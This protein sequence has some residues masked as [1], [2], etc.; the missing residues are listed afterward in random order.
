MSKATIWRRRVVLMV[1]V[2]LAVA[3][4]LTLVLRDGGEEG[5]D[6]DPSSPAEPAVDQ[7]VDL[8]PA[9]SDRAIEVGLRLPFDWTSSRKGEVRVLESADKQARVAISAPG[10]AADA[11]QLHDEV[12]AEFRQTYERFELSTRKKKSRVGGLK[13]RTSAIRATT[14][15]KNQKLGILVSTAE[16][17]K[18]A[19]VIVAYTPASDPGE[20]TVEA[21]TVINE[22]DLR[23]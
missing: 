11:D 1:V 8:G 20:S 23:G 15:K 5:S 14:K 18:R 2:G 22:L 17:K 6:N 19:Y 9:K 16:G 4:P 12:L 3:I 21:Q 13:S 7:A 10:P